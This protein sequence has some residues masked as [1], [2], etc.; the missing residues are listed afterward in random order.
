M[1]EP[2]FLTAAPLAPQSVSLRI[3]R[4][5]G[6]WEQVAGRS[7]GLGDGVSR[8]AKVART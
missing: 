7:L 8:V 1:V 6:S 2:P 5:G 3:G 4:G